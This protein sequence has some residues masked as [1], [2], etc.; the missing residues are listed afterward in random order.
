MHWFFIALPTPILASTGNVIDKVLTERFISRDASVWVLSLYSALFSLLVLPVLFLWN[1]DVF[2]VAPRDACC[3]VVAGM[4]EMVSV[5]LYLNA[6][7][8]A[9]ASTVVPM[10][11]TIPVMSSLLGYLVLGESLSAHELGANLGIVLGGAGLTI[12]FSGKRRPTFPWNAIFLMLGSSLCFVIFD[13]MFKVSARQNTFCAAMFWQ[14]VG[15][16]LLGTFIFVT[17]RNCRRSFL[18][19]VRQNGSKVF[20]LNLVNELLY[21]VGAGC[22]GY[23]LRMAP[24]ALVA[25]VTSY[26]PVFVFLIGIFMRLV[27][28]RILAEKVTPGRLLQKATSIFVMVMCSAFL[29]R[30]R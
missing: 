25:T 10:L 27:C 6:L 16:G 24:M 14:H 4:I 3:L 15:A 12:E 29:A 20:C 18:A 7:R 17:R 11:Q 8:K 30:S 19:N 22:Y 5:F 21:V 1:P 13:A 28:P 2:V 23:A 9:D 26:Q